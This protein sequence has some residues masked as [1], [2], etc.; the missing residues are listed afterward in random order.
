MSLVHKLK[1]F[2]ALTGTPAKFV[3]KTIIGY[4]V[5]GS[6]SVIELIEKCID[7]AHGTAK[8]SLDDLVKREDQE[9]VEAILGLMLGDLQHVVV[10]LKHLEGN[11]ED[12]K[13]TL[14]AAL[15]AEKQSL[16][17]AKAIGQ[18]I[19]QLSFVQAELKRLAAG[20]DNLIDLQRRFYASH[21]DYLEEQQQHNVAPGQLDERLKRIEEFIFAG[22]HGDPERAESLSAALS[23][24][25]PASAV[26]AVAVAASQAA[27]HNF[28]AAARSL[29]RVL[30][31]AI[32]GPTGVDRR[33][34]GKAVG[35]RTGAESPTALVERKALPTVG[36]YAV[37]GW[38]ASYAICGKIPSVVMFS[39]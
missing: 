32:A 9:R 11:P 28:V 39:D 3:A 22:R 23:Q 16:A 24:E 19:M 5:P 7:C 8:D 2:I 20:Q 27:E 14:T 10:Q 33:Q 29:E 13:K 12:A 25:Q 4:A 37:R 30:R 21:L 31:R 36:R 18:Q 34:A 38:P 15:R 17:A 35:A 26:L 6:S 1:T